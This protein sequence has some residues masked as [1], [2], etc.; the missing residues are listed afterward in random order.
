MISGRTR[1]EDA[2]KLL[3]AFPTALHTDVEAVT[4]ILRFELSRE[5]GS[6]S[7]PAGDSAC[8]LSELDAVGSAGLL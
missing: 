7:C 8:Q 2:D 4:D 5:A 6:A 1:D 3:R